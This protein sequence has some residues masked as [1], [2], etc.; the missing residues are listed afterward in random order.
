MGKRKGVYYTTH[1]QDKELVAQAVAGD[2]R[3][4]NLLLKKYKPI[5][6][7]A[8]YRRLPH[9]LPEDIE[10]ITM[11][12]LA[13]TF[14]C[15]KSYD[16]TKSKVFSWMIAC[17]HNYVNTIPN[18]KKRVTTTSINTLASSNKNDDEFTIEYE[19][20]SLDRFDES[21]DRQQSM[22]LLKLLLNKLPKGIA[23]VMLLRFWHGYTHEEIAR[24]LNIEKSSIVY[25]LKRGRELLKKMSDRNNLFE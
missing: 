6:Y 20:P 3:A 17:L 14:L 1:E 9:Y 16:P 18:Q 25:K 4:Y 19:I 5:L 7:T 12:V 11:I 24:E 23:D 10:D 15:L 8:A 2:Q 22:I 13:N 21:Y